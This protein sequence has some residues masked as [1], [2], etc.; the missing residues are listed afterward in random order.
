MSSTPGNWLRLARDHLQEEQV[1]LLRAAGPRFQ[2][3]SG[4]AILQIVH[5]AITALADLADGGGRAPLDRW[6]RP[7]A[8]WLNRKG[9]PT[10]EAAAAL[11]LLGEVLADQLRNF[12]VPDETER[13]AID[14]SVHRWLPEL[15]RVLLLAIPEE[16]TRKQ[17][18]FQ[19]WTTQL[20]GLSTLASV[21][22]SVLHAA[23]ILTDARSAA[24]ALYGR[25]PHEPLLEVLASD[26]DGEA[27]LRKTLNQRA[28]RQWKGNARSDSILDA[29]A[30]LVG[31][32]ASDPTLSIGEKTLSTPLMRRGRIVGDLVLTHKKLDRRFTAEDY[33]WAGLVADHAA[34]ALVHA[35]MRDRER[36]RLEEHCV[37]VDMSRA[38]AFASN[39][40]E[41]VR[42]ILEHLR[43]A[44][45]FSLGAVFVASPLR[46]ELLVGSTRSVDP[47]LLDRLRSQISASA[48]NLSGREILPE[49]VSTTLLELPAAAPRPRLDSVSDSSYFEFPI[50][51]APNQE[52]V[53]LLV[54]SHE[55]QNAFRELHRRFLQSIAVQA[56]HS[57]ARLRAAKSNERKRLENIVD[58]LDDGVLLLDDRRRI[59]VANETG[60]RR[61][62]LLGAAGVGQMLERLGPWRL[63][64]LLSFARQQP[65]LWVEVV[66]DD[67]LA[68]GA[69]SIEIVPQI[70]G[71]PDRPRA[72]VLVLRDITPR[73]MVEQ[74]ET[75][76]KRL[77]AAMLDT[78]PAIVVLL[79]DAFNVVNVNKYVEEFSGNSPH[80]L[81]GL[82]WI[83]H[84]IATGD[85]DS[86]RQAVRRVLNGE[87]LRGHSATLE[88]SGCGAREFAW[89]GA[90]LPERLG[91]GRIL[92]VGHDLTPLREAQERAMQSERLAAIGQMTTGLGHESRNA[93]QRSQ[94][95][96]DR[97]RLRVADRPDLVEFV[98]QLENAQEHLL[99]LYDEVRDYAAPVRLKKSL[100]RPWAI[101]AEAWDDLMMV[102]SQRCARLMQSG[103]EHVEIVGDLHG[104]KQVF[105]NIL[106]NSLAA[107]I[108]PVL[109]EVEHSSADEANESWLVLSFR[110]NGPGFSPETRMKLF[111]PFFSTKVKGTGLGMPI[112]RRLVEAHGGAIS[113]GAAACEGA[114][115]LV[116]LPKGRR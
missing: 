32:A 91:E 70:V 80:R 47:E 87:R 28:R 88:C 94:A 5:R 23:R 69:R 84:C 16:R 9:I 66:V 83:E 41:L 81:L 57:M 73:R 10:T 111:E 2:R 104:L 20:L 82:D 115:L 85:R 58:R 89:W 34:S 3:I 63:D 45:P 54:V 4:P 109:I 61:L 76:A 12:E 103:D 67:P 24:L 8:G 112:A 31:E 48:S 44:I 30:L 113:V 95:A 107:C 11:D 43:R 49:S 21:S 59:T 106:E 6:S 68:G 52:F 50:L 60:K 35:R 105:R 62:K 1:F 78:A 108:D 93:L 15:R 38:A 97:L 72:T 110:D 26:A 33:H 86:F 114:E 98:D 71:D 51:A 18:Q 101:V 27:D 14:E 116:E 74:R 75:N 22:Q 96:L 36:R 19:R 100:V 39:T 65:P 37:L 90:L 29:P 53:G 55:R 17:K 56:G 25:S 77:A 46:N 13:A 40:Q 64:E 79:D 102:H 42:T 92:L 7:L 99:Y